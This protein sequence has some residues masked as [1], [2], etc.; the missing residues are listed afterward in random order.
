MQPYIIFSC[1]TNVQ[2]LRDYLRGVFYKDFSI[3]K[4]VALL[5]T[6]DT[7]PS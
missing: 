4:L 6:K 7:A 2:K 5:F 3:M 1:S